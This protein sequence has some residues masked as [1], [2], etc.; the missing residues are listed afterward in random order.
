MAEAAHAAAVST[1]T[2][3]RIAKQKLKFKPI[4]TIQGKHLTTK[5]REKRKEWREEHL[6]RL[7]NGELGPEHMFWEDGKLFRVTGSLLGGSAQNCR[8]WGPKG[9]KEKRLKASQLTCGNNTA[10]FSP[11]YCL[12]AMGVSERGCAPP[13]FCPEGL[14]VD[15]DA[16]QNM[17][18]GA[19][20]PFTQ[21]LYYGE[22]FVFQQGGASAHT[23][24]SP[25]DAIAK[26]FGRE[27][28][29]QNPTNSPGL[30]VLDF[31]FWGD[32]GKQAQLLK[33]KTPPELKAAFCKD[34]PGIDMAAVGHLSGKAGQPGY[35]NA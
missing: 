13:Y 12:F 27:N 25:A 11:T 21:S 2:A 35:D 10:R 4:K 9:T 19:Y 33:P 17:A 16:Y 14:M 7:E 6:E 34:W 26:I 30:S 32:M 28:V 31:H 20:A 24:A 15:S 5:Q 1:T 29:I 3:R 23:S 18:R 8:V 22:Q